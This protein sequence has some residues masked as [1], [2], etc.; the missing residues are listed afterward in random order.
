MHVFVLL[1][2]LVL[3]V[4]S[5]FVFCQFA[6]TGFFLYLMPKSLVTSVLILNQD[7]PQRELKQ[8]AKEKLIEN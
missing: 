6:A 2:Y 7:R 3:L 5:C 1:Y 8:M 4:L